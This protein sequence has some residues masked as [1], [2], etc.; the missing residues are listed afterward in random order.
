[1]ED[2]IIALFIRISLKNRKLR[3]HCVA[4]TSVRKNDHCFYIIIE[5]MSKRMSEILFFKPIVVFNNFKKENKII[6]IYV[7]PISM[8]FE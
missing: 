6:V 1:M 3:F 4:S 5:I 2:V 8:D 7:R